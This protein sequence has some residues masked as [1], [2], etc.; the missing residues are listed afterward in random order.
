MTFNDLRQ[1]VG[2][3]VMFTGKVQKF[4]KTKTVNGV[5]SRSGQPFSFVKQ[6][7][8]FIDS[9]GEKAII[10]VVLNSEAEAVHGAGQTMTMKVKPREYN[11]KVYFDGKPVAMQNTP[12]AAQSAPQPAKANGGCCGGD[13]GRDR[14][15]ALSYAIK[16]IECGKVDISDIYDVSDHFVNYMQTGKHAT[17]NPMEAVQQEVGEE[18]PF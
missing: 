7:V 18:M 11:G 4:F 9:A 6:G 14:S 8:E 1:Q 10:D 13:S 15:I 5:S 2:A 12:N 16:L 17:N 3:E